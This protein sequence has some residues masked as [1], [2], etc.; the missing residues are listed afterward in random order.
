MAEFLTTL[1]ISSFIEDVIMTG[2]KK[3][4]LVSP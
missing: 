1:Q 4:T 2:K 3:I